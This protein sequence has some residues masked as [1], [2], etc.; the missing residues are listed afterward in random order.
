MEIQAAAAVARREDLLVVTTEALLIEHGPITRLTLNRPEKLNALNHD[1]GR[2]L[3]DVLEQEGVHPD[4]RVIVIA[5]AGRAFCAG[6]DV[7]GARVENAALNR[8][9][10]LTAATIGHYWHIQRA[11]RRTA[12][13]IIAQIHGN[14][15]GAGMDIALAADYAV[16]DTDATLGLVFAKRAIAAGMV[17]LPRHVGL[18]Q[19]TRLLYGGQT[20]SATEALSLG[21][22]SQVSERGMLEADVNALAAQLADGPT[23]TYGLIKEGLNR[24]YWP[25]LEEELRSEAFMQ[26]LARGTQDSAEARAAWRERRTPHFVG[27]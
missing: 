5:G 14:C 25:A 27:A 13:P 6:D 8:S 9:E 22:I 18:K 4:V 26:S 2:R 16:A 11:L 17:L 10:P 12:K 15:L 20:F 23:R 1:L 7:S 3:I 19:A 21:L 24:A